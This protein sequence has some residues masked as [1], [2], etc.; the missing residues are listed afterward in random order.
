MDG[1]LDAPVHAVHWSGRAAAE[2][3]TLVLF[4]GL[5]DSGECWPAAVAR[6]SPSYCIAGVAALGHGES[7]RFTP[8]Q[9]AAADPVEEMY[10]AAEATLASIVAGR[11]GSVAVV[12]HSMGGGIAGALAARRPDLVRAAVL[13][14]PAWRDPQ[15]RVVSDEI[16]AERLADCRGYLGDFAAALERGRAENPGWPEL[17]YEPCARAKTLVDLDFLA[18]GV[19]S[20]AHPWERL[21]EALE[22]PTLAL[23]RDGLDVLVS[24]AIRRRA[25]ALRNPHLAISVVPGAAHCVRREQPASYHAIVDRF[26]VASL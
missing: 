1:H 11:S 15:Y 9:L 13:E 23:T 7:P 5:G 24:D 25:E 16:I 2:A 20:F 19:A 18:L 3:P 6:W 17:E 14:E 21:V 26:L 12:G 22:V 10:A 4:H 8:E